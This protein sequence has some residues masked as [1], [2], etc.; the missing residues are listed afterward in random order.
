[1]SFSTDHWDRHIDE[2]SFGG[3]EKGIIIRG[4]CEEVKK[5]KTSNH[6]LHGIQM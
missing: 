4:N 5:Q 2:A 1:M 6:R 3:Y